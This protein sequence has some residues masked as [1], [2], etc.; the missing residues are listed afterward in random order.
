MVL[1]V[2][3]NGAL[4]LAFIICV[5]FFLGDLDKALNTPTGYPF[6]EVLYQATKSQAAATVLMC[7]VLFSGLIALFSTLASVSRLVWAFAQDRGL[8]FS[9]FFARV[10]QWH[11]ASS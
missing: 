3:I 1:S 11:S 4:N 7:F 6:I 5:L 9:S 2:L 10:S 8:P